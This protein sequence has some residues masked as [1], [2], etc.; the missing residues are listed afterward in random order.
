VYKL[1][2]ERAFRL[3][4]PRYSDGQLVVAK[5]V[6]LMDEKRAL[7]RL[8]KHN[9]S[10]EVV[11]LLRN[12][13]DR[14][15]SAYWY[16]RRM[17]WEPLECFEEALEA[18]PARFADDSIRVRNCRYIERGK[19]VQHLK[20][21]MEIFDRDQVAIFLTEDLRTRPRW[22]CRTLFERLGVDAEFVPDFSH[23]HNVGGVPKEAGA[24][25]WMYRLR[26]GRYY[27]LIVRRLLPKQWRFRLLSAWKGIGRR[28]GR[29]ERIPPMSLETRRR[30]VELYRPYN[31]ELGR[32]IGRDL[33]HWSH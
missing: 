7:L 11:V 20:V 23:L 3:Y 17:G 16:A 30:L 24:A 13:V 18:F 27:E 8:R 1:G 5:N 15:Y 9:P 4:F 6:G 26:H 12:P 25:H 21:L 14:A 31:E 22:V 33:T 32:L 19:Y 2:Y 28:F 29:V 10:V